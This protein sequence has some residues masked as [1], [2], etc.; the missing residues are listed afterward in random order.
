VLLWV[1]GS[2]CG[3]GGGAVLAPEAIAAGLLRAGGL[4]QSAELPPPPAQCTWRPAPATV[5]TYGRPQPLRLPGAP[6]AESAEYL[7]NLRSLGYL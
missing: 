4:P 2:S 6:A 7:Q 5:T 3:D 1:D